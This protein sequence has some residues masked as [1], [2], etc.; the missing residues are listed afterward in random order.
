MNHQLTF[1]SLLVLSP[2]FAVIWHWTSGKR[3]DLARQWRSLDLKRQEEDFW[4]YAHKGKWSLREE[5]DRRD[6]TGERDGLQ[7]GSSDLKRISRL[8]ASQQPHPGN[9][10]PQACRRSGPRPATALCVLN[11]LG[12]EPPPPGS[13]ACDWPDSWGG[14]PRPT[15]V[16]TGLRRS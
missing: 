4:L 13:G 5:Q 14:R 3:R 8:L 10:Q 6:R 12:R 11:Y 1:M 9:T 15:L 7:E 2:H 16:P